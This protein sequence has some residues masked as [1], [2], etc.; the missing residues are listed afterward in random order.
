M[1]TLLPRVGTLL[2]VWAHPDDEAYLSAGLMTAVR[3]SGGRVVVATA[4][5]GEHGT[6]DPQT[7]PP[8]RLARL[9]EQELRRSLDVM[10][11][12]EHVWLGHHDGELACLP[13]ED[14]VAEVEQIIRRVRPDTIVTFGPEGMTGHEDHQTIS[15]WVT[16]A[17]RRGGAREALWYATFTPHFHEHWGP[18]NE[19]VGL[20][21]ENA[22]PPVTPQSELAAQV[23]CTGKLA[24]AK[25][26]ALRAMPR[27][28]DSS[29]RPWGRRSTGSGGPWRALSPR[30]RIERARS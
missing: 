2:G 10:D 23:V 28:L 24:S 21:F 1:Q 4:T 15:S 3:R 26:R 5:R 25:H 7:W 13:A 17:W 14:G 12:R 19:Q 18:V 6:D 27:R 16:E 20:W 9:R 11:V 29:R 22:V 30:R 8:E